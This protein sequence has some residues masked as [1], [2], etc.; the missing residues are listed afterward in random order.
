MQQKPSAGSASVDL[1]C[2]NPK[3]V[4][5][6]WP[7]VAPW[8]KRAFERT[9]LGKFERLEKDVLTG[10]AILW[11]ASSGDDLVSAAVTQIE[12]SQNS[13][14]CYVLACGGVGVNNWVGSLT[15]IENYAKHYGCDFVRIAG[16]KGWARLLRNYTT[17][18]VVL[19]R[20]LRW[21]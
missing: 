2:V 13:K 16:R 20:R 10:G 7:R 5:H 14:V 4:S 18:M 15:F 8:I 11:I 1:L 17:K 3:D 9:D 6:Y 21:D 12:E 19:E